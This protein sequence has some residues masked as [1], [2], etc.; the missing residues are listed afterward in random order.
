[1]IAEIV[2][3]IIKNHKREISIE[4]LESFNLEKSYFTRPTTKHQKLRTNLPFATAHLEI[5]HCIL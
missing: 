5:F 4:F 3:I 2:I 1:M